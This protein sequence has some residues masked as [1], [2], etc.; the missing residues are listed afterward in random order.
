[1]G[2]AADPRTRN[3]QQRPDRGAVADKA[4]EDLRPLRGRSHRR[5]NDSVGLRPTATVYDRSAVDFVRGVSEPVRSDFAPVLWTVVIHR[6]LRKETAFTYTNLPLS[7]VPGTQQ[8]V[9]SKAL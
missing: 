7:T 1:M 6:F 9:L 2:R 8:V 3:Q 4:S 5:H